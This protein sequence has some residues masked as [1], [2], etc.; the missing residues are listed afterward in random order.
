MARLIKCWLAAEIWLA[1]PFT[2]E[3]G[4][5][6]PLSTFW[7]TSEFLHLL[8]GFVC[9]HAHVRAHI[10]IWKAVRPDLPIYLQPH[11][12][13]QRRNVYETWLSPSAPSHCLAKESGTQYNAICCLR[14]FR[15]CQWKCSTQTMWKWQ[16]HPADWNPDTEAHHVD[17]TASRLV[18]I[19]R[20]WPKNNRI[21]S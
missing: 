3:R 19:W 15:R 10:F 1:S 4:S 16:V 8:G 2:G 13:K 17:E 5:S 6:I 18:C 7:L 21:P 20:W 12:N 14:S 9:T 11:V